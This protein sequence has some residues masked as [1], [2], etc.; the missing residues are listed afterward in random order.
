MTESENMFHVDQD[1]YMNKIEQIPSDAE[2]SKFASMRIKLAWVSS[3]GPDIV[4]EVSNIAQVTRSMYEKDIIN[5]FKR[6]KRQSNMYM[7]TMHPFL[8]INLTATH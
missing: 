6:L 3:T 7:T 4:L 1:F 2:L 8:F 5:H